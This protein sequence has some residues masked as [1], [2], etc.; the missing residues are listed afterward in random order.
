MAEAVAAM[1]TEY[2]GAKWALAVLINRYEPHGLTVSISQQ[3]LLDARDWKLR[4]GFTTGDR[5]ADGRWLYAVEKPDVPVDPEDE[6]EAKRIQA[7]TAQEFDA[8]VRERELS[9]KQGDISDSPAPNAA[10]E[11]DDTE[12]A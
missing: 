6:A 4:S 5:P 9:E 3:E 1:K 10:L 7:M 8:Y 12:Q 2:E 11:G